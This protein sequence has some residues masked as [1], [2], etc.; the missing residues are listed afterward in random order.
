MIFKSIPKANGQPADFAIGQ[1]DLSSDTANNSLLAGSQKLSWPTGISIYHARLFVADSANNRVLVFN[2][3]PTGMAPHADFPIGQPDFD[4]TSPGTDYLSNFSYLKF[5]C[6]VAFD[7]NRLYLS[8]HNNH[9][10]L[11]FNSIPTA[12][13][14]KPSL[15]IGQ[16]D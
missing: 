9:R 4:T 5:P 8:D 12:P 14:A 2:T 16:P 7:D 15:V 1:P 13:N 10:V 6:F 3:V 11:V